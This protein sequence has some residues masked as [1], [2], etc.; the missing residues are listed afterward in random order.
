MEFIDEPIIANISTSEF[1]SKLNLKIN[2]DTH[3][4]IVLTT[5]HILRPGLQLAGYVDYF[6]N[7]RVQVI[8][9]AEFS[10]IETLPVDIRRER[11][12]KI[13]SIGFPCVIFSRDLPADE[14]FI[15][16]GQKY[17]IPIFTSELITTDIVNNITNYLSDLLA[18]RTQL[19]GVLV[20]ILGVGVLIMGNS[21]VGKS[22]AALELIK[23]GHRLCADDVVA[24]KRIKQDIIGTSPSLIRHFMEVRGIG[25]IDIGMMYGAGAVKLEQP[26]EIVIFLE[27][28]DESKEYERVGDKVANY[29]IL[30]VKIPQLVIPVTPGRNVAIILETAAANL[31]L[32]RL[33]YNAADELSR[34]TMSVFTNI[35]N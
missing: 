6:A 31:R 18:H 26:I 7:D 8:G 9:Q 25:I 15:E 4:E 10:F 23:R 24:A 5:D 29:E 20:D 32:N 14:L 1:A 3:S 27:K 35:N 34:R 22:E 33:G 16:F 17:N 2:Y 28:W 13:F 11:L 12:E 19:H 21:G 30:G